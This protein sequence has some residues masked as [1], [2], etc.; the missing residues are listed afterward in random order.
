MDCI[1]LRFGEAGKYTLSLLIDGLNCEN[2]QSNL[3]ITV[4]H[5]ITSIELLQDKFDANRSGN[6][7]VFVS[8]QLSLLF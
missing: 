2:I 5:P 1:G 6:K 8:P 4:V 3:S 7:A